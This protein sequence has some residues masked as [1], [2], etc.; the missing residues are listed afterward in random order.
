MK[1]SWQ[2]KQ[3][4]LR[5]PSIVDACKDQESTFEMSGEN[6]FSEFHCGEEK[7]HEN[8]GLL[9]WISRPVRQYSLRHYRYLGSL[10]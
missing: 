8:H 5:R 7:K 1:Y 9:D 3:A 6:R 10:R 2:N 4:P